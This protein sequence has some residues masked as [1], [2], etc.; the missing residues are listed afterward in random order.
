M[1]SHHKERFHQILQQPLTLLVWAER[2]SQQS[3]MP[4]AFIG[5]TGKIVILIGKGWIGC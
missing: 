1:W 5:K 2:P 4:V 3:Q